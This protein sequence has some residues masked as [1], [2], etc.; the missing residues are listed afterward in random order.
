MKSVFSWLK[1]HNRINKER[2]KRAN[3]LMWYMSTMTL[4][5]QRLIRDRNKIVRNPHWRKPKMSE[6]QTIVA[7]YLES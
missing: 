6:F 3:A 1:N 5:E 2:Q 7:K 4:P